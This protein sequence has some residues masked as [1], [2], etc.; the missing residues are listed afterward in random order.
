MIPDLETSTFSG[1]ETITLKAFEDTSEILF[2]AQ[3][4][5]LNEH[6]ISVRSNKPD[7]KDMVVV[8]SYSLPGS[9]YRIVLGAPL[10]KDDEYYL[11]LNFTGQLNNQ[12]RG[13]YKALYSEGRRER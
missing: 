1:L 11:N 9:R 6:S 4:L 2:H 10:H 8:E 13:F 3:N 5:S 12:L 7:S